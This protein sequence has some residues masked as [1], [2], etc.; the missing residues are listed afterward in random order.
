MQFDPSPP[1]RISS[2]NPGLWE[3][4]ARLS[5]RCGVRGLEFRCTTRTS[6]PVSLI[7]IPHPPQNYLHINPPPALD[8]TQAN[9]ADQDDEIYDP[10]HTMVTE[11][12]EPDP[13]QLQPS[14]PVAQDPQSRHGSKDE[15]PQPGQFQIAGLL[16]APSPARQRRKSALQVTGVRRMQSQS[17]C[18]GPSSAS[19]PSGGTNQII[20]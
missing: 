9:I 19:N 20:S 1:L 10:E 14:Y 4:L 11:V 3:S 2:Y 8:L 17:E 15:A 16:G 6:A 13:K 18:K 12:P 7:P 5:K